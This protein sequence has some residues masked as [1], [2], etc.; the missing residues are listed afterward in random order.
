[1]EEKQK[2]NTAIKFIGEHTK[3]YR[4]SL[5]LSVVLAIISV[6]LGL[7]PYI[8][9]SIIIKELINGSREFDF[10]IKWVLIALA[11][12]LLK[13]LF[14]IIST[15]ISHKVAFKTLSDIRLKIMKKLSKVPMGFLLNTPSGK[16]KDTIV[17]LVEKMEITFAHII[18][19]LTANFLGP[20]FLFI[21]L[22]YLD[23]RMALAS[24]ITVP[25]GMFCMKLMMRDYKEKYA[26]SVKINNEM[27]NAVVEYIGGIEVIKAFSQSASSYGKFSSAVK[28]N[29]AY[30]YNWMKSCM[31]ESASGK[32]IFP[33][34]LISVLPIGFL[35][36]A[37]GS[38]TG[39]NF[40]TIIILSMGIIDP[41]VDAMAYLDNLAIAGTTIEIVQDIFDWSE[42]NRPEEG[43]MPSKNDI[44]FKNVKFSYDGTDEYIIDDISLK[45]P[46][47]KL[48]AFVGHS[49][50]GKSTLARILAGLWDV[51]SGSIT[52]GGIDIKHISQKDLSDK[53]AYVSQ[54]NFLFDETIIDNIRTGNINATDEMVK[55]AATKAGCNEFINSLP[56]GYNTF[57]G[58]RGGHLSGGERQ[59]VSIARAI[60]KNTPIVILDEATAYVDPENEEII[61]SSINELVKGKTIIVIA[62]RL[63]TIKD[64]DQIVVIDKGKIDNL[65]THEEL[66]KKSKIYN[67]MWKAHIG[68]KEGNEND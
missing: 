44:E 25:I 41:I 55:E 16:L 52:I 38:L 63:S 2:E 65:G 35:F 15:G 46:S 18:P 68:G 31:I 22:L 62:H 9:A 14:S 34:V 45:I 5:I 20:I 7:V 4:G 29:A 11:G 8:G 42:L 28:S 47:N 48:T 37:S 64:A 54:D 1:M 30:Y 67:S 6:L 36:F 13:V 21:Y 59:R 51:D 24:L 17:D 50:S 40:I 10:Y 23:W 43:L 39:A 60:L 19:E 33:A 58:S 66:L 53:I 12:H 27:N 3:P 49:G 26:G 56:D 61:Q 57:V 32:V